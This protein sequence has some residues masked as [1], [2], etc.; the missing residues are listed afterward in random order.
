[1]KPFESLTYRGQFSRLRKLGVA[2]LSGYP[3]VQSRLQAITHA[4]NATFR[5]DVTGES[6]EQILDPIYQQ[7]RYLLRIHRPGYQNSSSI[8]SELSWLNALRS[9]AGLA[10]PSPVPTSA[11]NWYTE[12]SVPG[13]PQPRV[14][15]VLR[16]LKGRFN[17][18]NPSP[19]RFAEIGRLMAH[20]HS[21]AENWQRPDKFTR[22]SWDWDGLFGHNSGFNL[23]ADSV[24]GLLPAQYVKPFGL[25]AARTRQAMIELGTGP[26]AFGLIHAD[27]HLGNVLFAGDEARAIDFDDCGF[28]YWVY[29]FS[30][31][32]SEC[33]DC[34]NWCELR[35]GLYKGYT[36]VRPLPEGQ[37]AYLDTFLAARTVSL[38]L[39]AVDQAQVNPHFSKHLD[40]W[41][42]WAAKRIEPYLSMN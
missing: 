1:M 29:D 18:K 41:L 2:A 40:R 4:E 11:G 12:V 37:L 15:T 32:I 14:C 6:P 33:M 9:Q 21:H 23:N 28:G 19:V 7:S 13:V 3:F 16:W 17:E 42:D 36:E 20:L 10:V 5:L 22:R 24:W 27:L 31:P 8:A 26:E 25:V 39:W 34:D 35:D 30:V 38:V